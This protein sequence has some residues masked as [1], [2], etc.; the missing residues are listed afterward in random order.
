MTQGTEAAKI[1]QLIADQHA[2]VTAKDVD[3]ILSHYAT[4]AV[5][6]NVKPPFQ[7]RGAKDWRE[8]WASSLSHFPA[9]FG[10]ETEGLSVLTS[11]DLA[12]AHY[13][14]R[15]TG[16]PGQTW[17]RVST[18][19]QKLRGKWLISHEHSSVPFDPETSKAVFETGA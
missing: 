12:V 9:G 19:Y 2:A 4:D 18:V 15:F 14:L 8:V 7:I 11:G 1:R 5:V 10:I 3:G 13:F 16:M 17:I 6:F